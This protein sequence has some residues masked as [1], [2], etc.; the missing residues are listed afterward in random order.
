LNVA[1]KN[2]REFLDLLEERDELRR[3]KVE[4]DPHLEITEIADRV[5][6]AGGPALLFENVKGSDIPFAINLLGSPQRMAWA[7]G[8]EE[9]S[10]LERRLDDLLSM[11]M[12]PP[13]KSL[14][15]KLQTLN[16]IIKVGRIGPREVT[17]APVHEV[18][19][20]ENPSLAELPIPTCWPLDGGPYI[21]FPLV[22]THDPLTGKRN[23]GLYRLQKFD[24][25][26]LGMHWQRHKGGAE[27]WRRSKEERRRMEVAVAIGVD[28]TL[29]YSASAPLPP[30]IDEMVFAGFLR[31][32]PVETVK[33][34]TVNIQVPAHAEIVLEGWVDPSESRLEGPFGDHVGYYSLAEPFPVFH[35]TAVTRRRDPVFVSTIVGVPPMEDAW[36][37][38]ATERLF[39]PLVRLFVPELVDM[40]LPVHGVFH[41]FCIVSINKRYP[42]QARKVMHG[43]W[44]VGQLMFTKY[45]IVVDHDVDVQNLQEVMWRVGANTDPARDLEQARGPMDHLE[46]ATTT[47]HFG[48]KL[49]ID[50]TRKLPEEGFP[51]EWPP[52]ITM[53]DEIVKLVDER[54]S[55]Y[56]I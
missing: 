41:N 17:N 44:G 1:F 7:L 53:D 6:K 48:G 21:T 40:N 26:T 27:H 20:T 9:W 15:G 54:W 47:E 8:M 49:G 4:V 43:I 23:V 45:V 56:G 12:G 24:D 11:A 39:L 18:F 2:L 10:A 32:S 13:P 51:R 33:A 37:G 25:R 5:M 46:F 19:D 14:L 55:S 28:P 16:E 42:G 36:I 34:K 35:L 29:M 52:E 38:K 31:G 22:L 50:A 3:V 30:D